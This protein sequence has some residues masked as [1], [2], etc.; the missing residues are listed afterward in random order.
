MIDAWFRAKAANP[1]LTQREFEIKALDR[2]P[3]KA[4]GRYLRLILE[5][6]RSGRILVREAYETPGG[7]M[8]NVFNISMPDAEGNVRSFNI[9]AEPPP[10]Q[11]RF[12]RLDVPVVEQRIREHPEILESKAAQFARRY[13]VK[14][15]DIRTDRFNVHRVVRQR[16]RSQFHV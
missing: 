6:K 16:A 8:A 7:G 13:N 9:Y 10:G 4:D 11:A 15:S 2:N 12:S 14:Q 1:K 5:G 3:K